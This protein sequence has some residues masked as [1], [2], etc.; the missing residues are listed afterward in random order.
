MRDAV[1][2]DLSRLEGVAV[3]VVERRR[4]LRPALRHA[5][6]A[7]VIAPEENGVLAGLSRRVERE[8]RVLLGPS[9]GAVSGLSDKLATARCLAASG[10]ATPHTRAVSF[11]SPGLLFEASPP[12]VVKPRVGCGGRGVSIVRRRSEISA[13]LAAVR[14]ATRRSDFLVQTFVEGDAASVSL[15]VSGRSLDLG[16][17]R[18]RLAR[19]S[20]PE[21]LGGETFWPHRRSREAVASARAAI[22]ALA[23]AQEGV[24]GYI[25]VDVVLGRH[26]ATV[27]E[28]NPRLTTAY[29]GLRR[30]IRENLAGLI[31]QASIG[32]ALPERVSPVGRC[33]FGADGS[34][35]MLGE[36]WE[37]IAAGTS[38]ACI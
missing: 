2:A 20:R 38:A 4:D 34:I 11:R 35:A 8:R 33:R 31:L 36:E 7:L 18:Q 19:G 27:I 14:R 16:L 21:Y 5:D 13:A 1:V 24:R 37:P 12:F 25:G 6:A 29:A 32:R 17:N 30:S 15:I 9:S 28:I 3:V 22:A 10:V 23:R 26:G